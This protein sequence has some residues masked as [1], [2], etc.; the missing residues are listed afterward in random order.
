MVSFAAESGRLKDE[1]F[2]AW[3]EARRWR[4][5][6]LTSKAIQ[7]RRRRLKR[8]ERSLTAMDYPD[9]D[10]DQ[11]IA[12]GEL[13]GL[14]TKLSGSIGAREGG[15]PPVSLVP[16]AENPDGQLRNLLAVTRLYGKFAN[17]EDPNAHDADADYA[18]TQHA[19]R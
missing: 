10:V 12:R 5:Q 1:E 14:L 4:G 8:V 9:N 15:G 7:N 17:G 2:R 11:L 3:L 18:D 13:P 16:Q 6:P 19:L